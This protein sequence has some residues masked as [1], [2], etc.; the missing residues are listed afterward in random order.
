MLLMFNDVL[1]VSMSS[2][3]TSTNLSQEQ[4]EN[5]VHKGLKGCRRIGQ[6]KWNHKK[7]IVFL[8]GV[9]GRFSQC[10]PPSSEF[11]DNLSVNL[12]S[13]KP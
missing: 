1:A 12:V 3:K 10:L 6:T 2:K 9:K 11:D 13:K 7:F 4:L 8:V 5:V